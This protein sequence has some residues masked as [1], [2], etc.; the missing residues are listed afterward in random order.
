MVTTLIRIGVDEPWML[1]IGWGLP[2]HIQMMGRSLSR[3]VPTPKLGMWK[4]TTDGNG[5][6]L[7][8]LFWMSAE[9]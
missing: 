4:R 7:V 8:L 5:P 3:T 6:R 9:R 2:A 1:C